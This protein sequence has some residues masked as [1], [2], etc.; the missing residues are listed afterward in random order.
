MAQHKTGKQWI[1]ILATDAQGSTLWYPCS[2][3]P[4]T[5]SY[6]VFGHDPAS[7]RRSSLLRFTA[8]VRELTGCYLLGNGYRAYSPVLMRF[9]STDDLSPFGEGDA[10]A[11]AYCQNDPVNSVDPSGHTRSRSSSTS[12]R[13]ST[14]PSSPPPIRRETVQPYHVNAS[15]EASKSDFASKKNE[16]QPFY[17]SPVP[18]NPTQ[19]SSTPLVQQSYV[20]QVASTP[21]NLNYSPRNNMNPRADLTSFGFQQQPRPPTMPQ[22][23]T[24]TKTVRTKHD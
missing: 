21:N 15:L 10:N 7:D 2:Q 16:P 12:S 18:G 3:H 1:A 11:Y 22:P 19:K 24:S 14:P 8:Q 9:L 20:E 17:S 23:S 5:I 13:D 4:E 6:S